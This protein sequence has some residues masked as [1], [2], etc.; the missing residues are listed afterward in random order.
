MTF[1]LIN[2]QGTWFCDLFA[3]ESHRLFALF[4]VLDHPVGL[5]LAYFNCDDIPY[6]RS[7][8]AEEATNPDRTAVMASQAPIPFTE[9]NLVSIDALEFA[10]NGI[11]GAR[12]TL[13]ERQGHEDKRL[14]YL[15]SFLGKWFLWRDPPDSVTG[16]R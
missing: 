16:G 4:N 11:C 5:L 9:S 1:R 15:K 2:I 12:V 10:E 6:R 3:S 7:Y 13:S 8:I 14:V